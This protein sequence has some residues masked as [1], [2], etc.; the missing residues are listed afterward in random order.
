M[1]SN[2]VN[3][4]CWK[5]TVCLLGGYNVDIERQEQ[6]FIFKPCMRNSNNNVTCGL[7]GTARDC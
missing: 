3:F 6:T 2:T 1:L 5:E 4:Q 7:F